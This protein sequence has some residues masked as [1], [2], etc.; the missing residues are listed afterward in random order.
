MV[1]LT[2][3]IEDLPQLRDDEIAELYLAVYGE[4]YD[5]KLTLQ[6]MEE[7]TNDE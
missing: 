4:A 2:E 6:K 5:R 7:L 1:D 3:V